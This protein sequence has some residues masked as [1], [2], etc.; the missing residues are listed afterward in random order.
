VALARIDLSIQRYSPLIRSSALR[1]SIRV[2][3]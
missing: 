1:L 3:W 2:R